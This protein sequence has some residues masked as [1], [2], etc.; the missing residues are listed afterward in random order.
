MTDSRQTDK[1]NREAC[2][3]RLVPLHRQGDA[4]G[5]GHRQAGF[6]GF[7]G[8]SAKHDYRLLPRPYQTDR[9]I[10]SAYHY[11]RTDH[12]PNLGGCRTSR[13]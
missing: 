6:D 1:G 10:D 9:S 7:L 13:L 2:P 3:H 8:F 5:D 11:P 12:H 4:I